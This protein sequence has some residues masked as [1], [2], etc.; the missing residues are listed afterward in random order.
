MHDMHFMNNMDAVA[1]HHAIV[2]ANTVDEQNAAVAQA[3]AYLELTPA[4]AMVD[5]TADYYYEKLKKFVDVGARMTAAGISRQVRLKG[6]C[7]S[8]DL[9]GREGAI[10]M[11][12]APNP[13]RVVV[14][15]TDGTEVKPKDSDLT[16]LVYRLKMAAT[17]R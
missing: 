12:A 2:T 1:A 15:L 11:R 4:S 17:L 14:C 7:S 13:E 8:A 3:E 5:A 16:R 6:L 9:N 10:V